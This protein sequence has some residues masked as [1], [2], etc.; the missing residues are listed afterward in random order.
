MLYD[1]TKVLLRGILQ[2]LQNPEK[3]GWEDQVELSG[4][5]LYEMHQ[6]ASSRQRRRGPKRIGRSR[7]DVTSV[8]EFRMH[9]SERYL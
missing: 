4:E 7:R 5:C 3:V 6:M 2:S 9:Q 1:S 8:R